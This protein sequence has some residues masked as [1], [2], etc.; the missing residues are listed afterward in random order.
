MI[1]SIDFQKTVELIEKSERILITTHIKPDGDACGSVVAMCDALRAAGRN[2][3]PVLATPAPQ[4]YEFLFVDKAAVLGEDV[5][6]EE[7]T[8]G[9]LGKFDLIIV[10]DA[11]SFIQLGKFE[12]YLRQNDKPVLVIDH[13][14]TSDGVGDVKLIDST[15]AA[16]GLVV[17]E[18]LEHAGWTVTEKIAEAL[19]V[20]IATDTGWFQFNNTDSRVH[21]AI[22]ELI[23][24]GAKPTPIYDKLYHNFSQAR[25]GLMAAALNT[26]E[27]HLDG[28]YATMEISQQD[29]QRTG[30]DYTDTENLI[31]ECHRIGTVRA[32]ALFVEL[33][34]GRIRCS[35]RSRGTINVSQIAG[36]FGGGGHKMASGTYLP[37]PMESAKKLILAE[38]KRHL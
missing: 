28:R 37:G 3:K 19:F 38:M 23:D 9:R 6:I 31:N 7:L 8:A 15:A 34:D 13:H 30:T 26:L 35:L 22:A 17:F 33:K 16:T 4:W 27:L 18:L 32:S 20:A 1:S 2:I 14:V 11:D 25:F 24:A 21:R 12:E 36:K 5:S 10:V 29:F